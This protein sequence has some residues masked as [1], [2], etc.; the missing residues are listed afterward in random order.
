MGVF[1]SPLPDPS[2]AKAATDPTVNSV[3]NNPAPESAFPVDRVEEPRRGPGRPPKLCSICNKPASECK[4]HAAVKFEI[5]EATVRGLFSM[6][7]QLAATSLALSTGLPLKDLGELWKFSDGELAVVV[8][9]ATEI[10]NE[11][12]PEWLLRYEKEIKL[13]FVLV[14][15]L[16]AKM[17]MTYAMV[18]LRKSQLEKQKPA[19]ATPSPTVT[20]TED[21]IR[22]GAA[23]A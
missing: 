5:G 16:I 12:A 11:N 18:Q 8:P 1:P 9:P 4:G 3:K 22:A 20:R 17:S 23:A 14:P 15:C 7:S 21:P 10:I 2:T 13:G 6:V 19:N